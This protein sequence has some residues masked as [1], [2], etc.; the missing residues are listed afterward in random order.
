MDVNNTRFH[1]LHGRRDWG[2]V[3][4]DGDG[5]TEGDVVW[6]AERGAVTLRPLLYRFPTED[7]LWLAGRRGAARDGYGIWY[8]IGPDES[9]IEHRLVTAANGTRYWPE[10][11]PAYPAPVGSLFGPADPPAPSTPVRMRGLAITTDQYLVVGGIE[12]PSLLIFDL[13]GGGPPMRLDWTIEDDDTPFR[14]FDIAPRPAGGVWVLD[15][16]PEDPDASPRLW[17]LDRYFR[18]EF[19]VENAPPATF[20]PEEDFVPDEPGEEIACETSPLLSTANARPLD[21]RPI[22]I[23]VLPDDTVLILDVDAESGQTT[24]IRFDG[25]RER[26]RAELST[27]ITAEFAP[28]SDGQGEWRG[29]DLAFV[30]ASS[31]RRG[32]TRG[33][34]YVTGSG[35]KQAFAFDL[36]ADEDGLWV[37]LREH[38][39][40]LRLFSGK[41]LV[42]A[43]TGA[44][45]D[46]DDRWLPVTAQPKP[47]YVSSGTVLSEAFDGRE[48]RC[49]WHRLLLDACIP[50][51]TRVEVETRTADD[52]SLLGGQPWLSEPVLYR[53]GRGAEIPFYRPFSAHEMRRDGVG[54]WELLFQRAEGRYLQ[55]RLTLRGTGRTTPRLYELRVHYPRFSYLRKYL[56]AV[57]RR[58]QHSASFLDRYLANAEGTFTVIE[59]KIAEIQMLFDERAVDAEY[60]DWL[61]SWLGVA[62]DSATFD[63]TRRRL[64]IRHAPAIFAQRGTVD[65]MRLMLRLALDPCPDDS[66]FE[67]TRV[68]C[69]Q[70]EGSCMSVGM[71]SLFGVRLVERF[72]TRGVPGVSFGD[73][74]EA[75]QPKLV[76]TA[77]SWSPEL[78]AE[79]LH[80][81]YRLFLL[82]RHGSARAVADAWGVVPESFVF[83]DVRLPPV[84][85]SDQRRYQDWKLFVR[86]EL[87]FTY[88]E[89]APEDVKVYR[90]F[91]EQR[92]AQVT[93]L[94][95]RHETAYS[96]FDQIELPAENAFPSHPVRLYDWIQFVSLVLPLERHASRFDVLV[97]VQAGTRMSDQTQRMEF[98]RLLVDREK[99]AHTEFDVKPYWALF[100][101][102]EA[103]LGLDTLLDQGS[104]YTALLLG[105]AHLAGAYVERGHPWNVPDRFVTGRE[106][107]D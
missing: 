21:G 69:E 65:G 50:S 57:Y 58:D 20:V 49:V 96:S 87:G 107:P 93:R 79:H 53:R 60:L 90:A 51:G 103:R 31:T 95:E 100:R 4:S 59:G 94:N 77:A 67:S 38:F 98:V 78:G 89:V 62:F 75:Y 88:A 9:T 85:P 37:D 61:G 86:N 92:Y 97:P 7:D 35:G 22:A 26:G 47:R 83:D 33:V 52:L 34:L 28:D 1:L 48:V 2:P 23:D 64:F 10:D 81:A 17:A 12:P 15:S 71:T 80:N 32:E 16:D 74:T 46:L 39:Y 91:L 56:P 54:T 36:V 27:R 84:P 24:L 63:E 68:D 45:Y 41:A 105:Q 14:P 3:L 13:H 104:R 101:V 42:A 73:P 19:R 99:P 106:Q 76:P 8:W 29:Y 43:G 44:Y 18:V 70:A 72:Q 102:G 11:G 55:L 6:N 5:A 30:P 66:L 82:Q 25:V 40:P